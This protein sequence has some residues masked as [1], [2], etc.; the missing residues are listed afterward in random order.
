M[1]KSVSYSEI[2][3]ASLM[4]PYFDGLKNF[5]G[6]LH[7]HHLLT[8]HAHIQ[9]LIL[10]SPCHALPAVSRHHR[11]N[12]NLVE[13]NSKLLLTFLGPTFHPI[14]SELSPQR[15][16]GDNM[17]TRVRSTQDTS[18]PLQLPDTRGETG[19]KQWCS[20]SRAPPAACP[21]AAGVPWRNKPAL[22][23]LAQHPQSPQPARQS[24]REGWHSLK[25]RPGLALVPW[26]C[27]LGSF[28]YY[29]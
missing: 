24:H 11:W 13:V 21:P 10:Q 27:Y 22:Q 28:Y 7:F 4:S 19:N 3:K 5:S 17:K 6:F 16:V 25:Q 15:L 26:K 12:V 23:T 29:F 9:T 8:L 1:R 14:M 20:R 2:S 18:K